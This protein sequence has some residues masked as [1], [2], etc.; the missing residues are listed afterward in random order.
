[1]QWSLDS[2]TFAQTCRHDEECEEDAYQFTA[3]REFLGKFVSAARILLSAN[4]SDGL[5]CAK[6][7]GVN[8]PGFNPLKLASVG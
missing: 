2:T 1:M 5:C 3:R 6:S 8:A 4:K 7:G